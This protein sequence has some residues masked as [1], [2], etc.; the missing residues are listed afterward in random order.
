MDD[1][2]IIES[3]VFCL[4]PKFNF[5]RLDYPYK[6]TN[7]QNYIKNTLVSVCPAEF[8]LFTKFCVFPL[9]RMCVLRKIVQKLTCTFIINFVWQNYFFFSLSEDKRKWI[10]KLIYCTLLSRLWFWVFMLMMICLELDQKVT[11]LFYTFLDKNFEV[12]LRS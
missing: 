7:D 5:G 1:F 12:D 3:S 6:H 4:L 2:P 11:F 9:L 10:L 8:V